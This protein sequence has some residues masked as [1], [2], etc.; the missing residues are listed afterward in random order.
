M[1]ATFTKIATVTVG[2][3]GASSID[4]SSIA[5]TYTDIVIKLSARNGDTGI[6]SANI[7]FNNDTG[8]NYTNRR[9]YGNGATASSGVNSSIG[10]IHYTM[11]AGSDTTANTFGNT[12]IYIPNYASSN[13][14]GVSIDGVAENNNTTAYMSLTAG[15]WTGTSVIS[16]VTLTSSS[17]NFAQYSTA[18]LYGIKNA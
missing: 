11:V 9:I 1:A 15:L 12:E 16:R 17:G 18:T 4:F 3:G 8:S 7:T 10:F 6:S 14:K 13:Q 2:S 5:S